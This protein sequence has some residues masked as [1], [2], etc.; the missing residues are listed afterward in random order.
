MGLLVEEVEEVRFGA[1]FLFE[2]EYTFVS[3]HGADLRSWIEQVAKDAGSGRAG[4]KAGRQLTLAC[5]VQTEGAFFHHTLRADTVTEVTLLRVDFFF[6]DFRFGPIET[7][8][9]VWTGGFAVTA[10]NAPVVVDND[11]AV[12]LFPSS[13]DRTNVD[14]RWILALLALDRHVKFI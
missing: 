4:F 2:N 5:A 14:A 13:L 1:E 6:G 10:A 3:Q 9:V 8:S 7:T 11:D 12:G